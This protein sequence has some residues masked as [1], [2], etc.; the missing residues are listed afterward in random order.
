MI[1]D[2]QRT[3]I[4]TQLRRFVSLIL[5]FL[6]IIVVLLING[7]GGEVWGM[8][9]HS[10]ALWIGLVYVFSLALESIFELNYIYYSDQGGTIIF[11]YFSMSVLNR[12]KNS[13]EIPKE[14]FGGYEVHTSL[15]GLKKK[16]VL[17]HRYKGQ[18]APYPAVSI[19]GLSKE[20]FKNMLYGMDRWKLK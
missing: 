11:R 15:W 6:G 5:F 17:F 16:I 8:N 7:W 3:V 9:S 12:K 20:E 18:N 13:I 4:K 1:I 14:E 10:L 2:I 19:T